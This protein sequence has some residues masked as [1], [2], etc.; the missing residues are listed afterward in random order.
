VTEMSAM[1]FNA[2]SFNQDLTGWDV[3]QVKSC[4][5]MFKGADK[6]DPKLKPNLPKSCETT[7]P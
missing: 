6:M 5:D 2:R 7:P 3:D 1:F 4:Q